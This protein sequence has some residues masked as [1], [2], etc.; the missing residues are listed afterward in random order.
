[1]LKKCKDSK[2]DLNLCLLDYRNAWVAGLKISPAQLLMNR[3]LRTR[4]PVEMHTLKPSIPVVNIDNRSKQADQY[5][6]NCKKE[7]GYEKGEKVLLQKVKKGTWTRGIIVGKAGTPRSYMVKDSDGVVYRRN[8][9]HL[10]KTK[11][12]SNLSFNDEFVSDETDAEQ[13]LG[14]PLIRQKRITKIPAYLKDYVE[15]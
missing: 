15:Y 1:M 8:T 7:C 3:M 6:K 14:N 13:F 9:H 5:N 2:C 11:Y 12:D 4:L 10:K